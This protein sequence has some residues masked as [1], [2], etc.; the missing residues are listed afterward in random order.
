M[1]QKWTDRQYR[2]QDNDA[3]SHKYVKTYCNTNKFPALTF[4]GPHSKPHCAGGLSKYYHLLSD[5]KLGNGACAILRISCSCATCKSM[6]EKPCISGIPSDKE[7]HYK[8]VIYC[9]YCTV[10]GSFNNCNII[11]L[12]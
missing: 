9:N 5:P 2:V 1:E 10:L 12:S 3:V 8:P 6:M 11:L 7:Y 4:C